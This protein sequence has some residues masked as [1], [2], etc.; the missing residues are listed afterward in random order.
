M[1]RVAA[2]MRVAISHS[3]RWLSALVIGIDRNDSQG[4][5]SGRSSSRLQLGRIE[6]GFLVDRG[7]AVAM[8]LDHG[9][10]PGFLFFCSE[11]EDL[12]LARGADFF[13][14]LVVFLLGD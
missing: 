4:G 3:S 5:S 7:L 13:E 10:L 11:R 12:G 6:A 9:L 2:P 14:R 1:T 8:H